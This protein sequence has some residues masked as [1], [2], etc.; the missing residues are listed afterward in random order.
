M[1]KIAALNVQRMKL[2]E[3]K[4][5]PD[6]PRL[7][8]P[9][10]IKRLRNSLENYGYAKGS[11]V[12]NADGTI[13]TGHGMYESMLEQGVVEADVVVV[14]LPPGKA[15]AFMI[16]DNRLGDLSVFDQVQLNT[17]VTELQEMDVTL[18]EM[19]FEGD[20]LPEPMPKADPGGGGSSTSS[21]EK[22]VVCPECGHEF[23]PNNDMQNATFLQ[24][25]HVR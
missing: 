24:K 16:A 5:H 12:V 18:E 14:D 15:E 13:L 10:Q 2:S 7:H 19:G 20:E 22:I 9:D 8:S 1:N 3:I 23:I 4:P 25:V 11:L 6:N 17:L 21:N